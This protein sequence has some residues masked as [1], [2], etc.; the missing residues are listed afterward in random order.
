[1]QQMLSRYRGVFG[2]SLGVRMLSVAIGTTVG[3]LTSA[4]VVYAF[5]PKKKSALFA[6]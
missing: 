5:G 2:P 4:L 3:L 1:M 6:F